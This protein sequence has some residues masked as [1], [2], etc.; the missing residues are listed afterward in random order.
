MGTKFHPT[1]AEEIYFC[2][3]EE[4]VSLKELPLGKV[5]AFQ[6]ETRHPKLK[7]QKLYFKGNK[8]QMKIQHWISGQGG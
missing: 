4:S 6:W 2:W 5:T 7:K 1:L 3:G 8:K